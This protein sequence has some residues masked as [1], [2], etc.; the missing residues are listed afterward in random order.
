M[1]E[2]RA[3]R[4]TA[5]KSSSMSW[6]VRGPVMGHS[7]S[8]TCTSPAYSTEQYTVLKPKPLSSSRNPRIRNSV[9]MMELKVEGVS[10]LT[11]MTLPSR[12]DRPETPPMEKLLG[13]LKKYTPTDTRA[14]PRVMSRNSFTWALRVSDMEKSAPF[15]EVWGKRG[16]VRSS[17]LRPEAARKRRTGDPRKPVARFCKVGGD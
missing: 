17:G 4:I 12:M 11:W 10:Q 3:G 7:H 9:L 13:N 16:G 1:A 6:S 2:P 14:V 8:K 15:D 5:K